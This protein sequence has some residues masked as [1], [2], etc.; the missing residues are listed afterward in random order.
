MALKY[1][2]GNARIAERVFGWGRVNI[3]VG[4][5]EKRTGIVCIGAQAVFRGIK[6]WEEKYPEAAAALVKLAESHSQQDPTFQSSIAY[7]RLTVKEALKQLQ[8]QGFSPLPSPMAVRQRR[9]P[10][11]ELA[12]RGQEL[13]EPGIRQ[14]VEVGNEGKIMAI[15]SQRI[16]L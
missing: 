6:R 8:S 10:K 11:E 7:T 2:E 9:Y 13:Y 4:L 3:E 16:S 1:C 15:Q 14:Q 5:A 12:Q